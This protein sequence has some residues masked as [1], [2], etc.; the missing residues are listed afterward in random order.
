[1]NIQE[2]DR[3]TLKEARD[4]RHEPRRWKVWRKR[5]DG[6]I[7]WWFASTGIPLLAAAL[8]P[9]ANLSSIAALVTSW[10]QNNYL[11]SDFVSDLFGVPYADPKWCYWLNVVSLICG[12]L[13]NIFLLFN[14]TQK[15]RYIIALPATIILWY[16][17]SGLLIAITAC[18]EVYDPPNRPFEIYTQGY[19]YAVAAAI[20]YFVCSVLLMVNMLGY[21]LGHY[22]DHFAL[23]DNQRTLI[24]QTMFFF[25]WMAGGAAIYSRIQTDAGEDQ[26]T[27]PNALY[28]C[29][30]TILTVGFGDLVATT[31]LGRGLL[32]PYSV[33]GIITLGLV[34]S[35]LYRAARELG[36][37]HIVQKDL[38]RRREQTLALTAT[39][40][41]DYRHRQHQLVR[42]GT[43]GRLKISAPT[44]PRPYRTAMGNNV[45]RT[46][47]LA[48]N[49]S[50]PI[51]DR[52]PRLLLLKEEKDRFD[53]MRRIQADSKRFKRWM[54][55][56][57]SALYFCYISLLTIG[58]GDLSPKSNPGR[59]FFVIWSLISVPT[60]TI[61][62]SDLGDTV[63]AKFK[64]WSNIVAD[65]T[66]LPKR[67]I[68]QPFVDK[69]PWLQQRIQDHEAK[70]RVREGF[71]TANPDE[72]DEVDND[73]DVEVAADAIQATNPNIT[74]LAEEAETDLACAPTLASLARRIAFSI[75][76]V[77]FDL[78]LDV[79]K[80]YSYEE[81]VEFTR[82]IRYT[83]PR[84][85]NRILGT[86]L[87]NET[88]NE[89][90]LVN[91]DW[92]VY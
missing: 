18:M 19:W 42:R 1:M 79:P 92:L 26:W 49:F 50:V 82:L 71:G 27:F 58:Y 88:E 24:L 54:A 40:S 52:K 36:E 72:G 20:F 44:E 35:S 56:F 23:S 48:R 9:F 14:F 7:S 78:R 34:V 16:I 6:E 11:N 2:P 38:E 64:K 39:N 45:P 41:D 60:M 69:N 28:F 4:S 37:D 8:G 29:Y 65:F 73:N 5:T 46:S 81:W 85:L 86:T 77:S 80:R 61:L 30:V 43:F 21:F 91:W 66:V 10:R 25:I 89:E 84:R 75:K 68:W 57:W 76:K 90:G 67:D 3:N 70:R 31:D 51:V 22:P 13:G 59:C 33:G 74:S 63:V 17:S 83:T 53:A 12:F 47:T 62:V 87:T 15:I 32:F 55:L